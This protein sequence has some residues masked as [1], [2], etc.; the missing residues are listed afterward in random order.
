MIG[1]TRELGSLMPKDGSFSNRKESQK[2]RL[3]FLPAPMVG[4]GRPVSRV[5]MNAKYAPLTPAFPNKRYPMLFLRQKAPK[6]SLD[7]ADDVIHGAP[8]FAMEP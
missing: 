3:R 6:K 8:G 7:K 1:S 5:E 4:L 2:K